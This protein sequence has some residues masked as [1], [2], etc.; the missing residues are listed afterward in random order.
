MS[1][2]KSERTAHSGQNDSAATGGFGPRVKPYDYFNRK[3]AVQPFP[4]AGVPHGACIWG[5]GGGTVLPGRKY[6]DGGQK[7]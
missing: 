6:G 1:E 4:Y 7:I 3:G 5:D 2:D